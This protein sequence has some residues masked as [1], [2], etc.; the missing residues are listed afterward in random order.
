MVPMG[1]VQVICDFQNYN[2]WTGNAIGFRASHELCSYFLYISSAWSGSTSIQVSSHGLSLAVFWVWKREKVQGTGQWSGEK[3][4]IWKNEDSEVKV[5]GGCQLHI[6]GPC[7]CPCCLKVIL[8]V[9]DCSLNQIKR[10]STNHFEN[11]VWSEYSHPP[12]SHILK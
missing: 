11:Y 10:F 7:F 2:Y 9:H 5:I 6:W 12:F 1:R 8:T 3:I 4:V